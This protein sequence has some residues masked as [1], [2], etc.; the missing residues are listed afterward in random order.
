MSISRAARA[1]WCTPRCRTPPP[2]A[3]FG[4]DKIVNLTG[5]RGEDDFAPW[6]ELAKI[7]TDKAALRRCRRQRRVRR[8]ASSSRHRQRSA[9]PPLRP[10][11]SRGAVQRNRASG[12]APA[13]RST[14]R[15]AAPRPQRLRRGVQRAPP[16]RCRAEEERQR[17]DDRD[18]RVR[19]RRAC[20]RRRLFLLEPAQNQ[21][22]TTRV[23]LSRRTMPT[24][25]ARFWRAI[26]RIPRRSADRARLA[27]RAHLRS[28]QRR[29]HDPKRSRA[30]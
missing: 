9:T 30:S 28:G 11:R 17:H 7:V 19:R 26:R 29:R 20:G 12:S 10:R 22:S 21:A 14:A 24:R 4:G 16:V 6:R 8:L 13:R 1:R 23:G 15:Q 3:S 27:G 5:W 2:R 25:C 18:H